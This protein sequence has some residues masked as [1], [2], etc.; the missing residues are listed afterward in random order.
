MS[1]ASGGCLLCVCQL[2]QT[3]Q[4]IVVVALRLGTRSDEIKSHDNQKQ[5]R[6]TNQHDQTALRR[7]NL[8]ER[9]RE[10]ELD[11]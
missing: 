5:R 11:T 7:V 4:C 8:S 2:G 10:R 1:Q 9:E 3:F 6:A